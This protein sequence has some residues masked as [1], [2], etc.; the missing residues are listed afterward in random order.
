MY[1][2]TIQLN[3]WINRVCDQFEQQCQSKQAC[4]RLDAI[5]F[6]DS[7]SADVD[8]TQFNSDQREEILLEL[9]RV[10]LELASQHE[11]SLS[12]ASLRDRYPQYQHL[13]DRLGDSNPNLIGFASG[14]STLRRGLRELFQLPDNSNDQSFVVQEGAS[15]ASDARNW[16]ESKIGTRMG[17]FELVSHLGSGGMGT[18]WVAKQAHPVRREVAL[19]LI[20]PGLADSHLLSR[21]RV[22]CQALAVMN[23]PNIARMLEAHVSADGQP[24]LVMELVSGLSITQHAA[25]ANL[26]VRRRVELF[27]PICLAIQHAH[28]KR[29][30]HRD[31]KPSNI[32]VASE[33]N[34]AIPKV[35]DFGLAKATEDH[36]S[37]LSLQ[38]LGGHFLG[39]PDYM[40]PEQTQVGKVDIDTRTDIYSLGAVLYELLTGCRP[41]GDRRLGELPLDDTLRIIRNQDPA[42]PSQRVRANREGS[43]DAVHELARLT[44]PR[45]LA[46]DLDWI[47][48]KAL[49]KDRNRRYESAAALAGDLTRYLQAEPVHARPPSVHYRLQKY[50][51]RHQTLI[52]SLVSIFVLLLAGTTISSWFALQMFQ[53]RITADGQRKQAEQQR[54]LAIE[55]STEAEAARNF[56]DREAERLRQESARANFQLANAR[57]E[58]NRVAEAR[59]LLDLVPEDLR[60]FEWYYCNQAFQGSDLTLYGH[61]AGVTCVAFS[62][63]GER[64]VSGSHDGTVRIWN[65]TTGAE[66][67]KFI[68]HRQNVMSVSF[69]PDGYRIASASFDGVI[70]IWDVQQNLEV[71]ELTGHSGPV[72]G[73]DYSPNGL[74]LVT[75]GEDKTLR[76][77]DATSG[78]QLQEING[79]HQSVA[80]V[81][82][83]ADSQL[84]AGG[85]RDNSIKVYH[86]DSGVAVHELN[87]HTW[88]V[89]SIQFS[90]D[91]KRM[92]SGGWDETLRIWDLSTER[93][94]QILSGHKRYINA[95]ACSPDGECVASA[96]WDHAIRIWDSKKGTQILELR[97]HVAEV[98]SI[99]YSPDGTRIAS[100]AA[101]HTVKVWD[102]TTGRRIVEL[103]GHQDN[104]FCVSFLPDGEH[105]VSGSQDKTIKLW[106]LSQAVA[107]SEFIGHTGRITQAVVSPDGTKLASC[108][109]DQSL[110]LWDIATTN[111][112]VD[113][114]V[115]VDPVFATAFSP[116]GKQVV[117][118]NQDHTL[119]LIDATN[120]AEIR[121]FTGHTSAISTVAFAANGRRIA[122]GGLD[123]S[124]IIW[125]PAVVKP[126]RVLTGHTSWVESVQ[127]SADGTRLLSA[128][129]DNA[130]KMWDVESG[131]EILN[132]SGHNDRVFSAVFSPDGRRI[133]SGSNDNTIKLWDA[134][135]GHELLEFKGH[136]LYV[137]SVAFS[138]DGWTIAS[139]G[140]DKSIKLWTANREQEFRELRGHKFNVQSVAISENGQ[141]IFSR[142]GD[143]QFVWDLLTG[144][145]IEGGTWEINANNQFSPDGRWWVSKRNQS[146]WLVDLHFKKICDEKNY[147]V[148]KARPKV[149]WH[150]EQLARA[151]QD[152]DKYASAF[153]LR[154]LEGID[155]DAVD[156]Q[157]FLLE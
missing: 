59:L 139:C 50:V 155:R 95:V 145:R 147:R 77:W 28:Q 131:T 88:P 22:E 108:A 100:C 120:G 34:K 37:D 140:T 26:D 86:A 60:H 90:G 148:A 46:G 80:C 112:D 10:Q 7:V 76:V 39:T 54:E 11:S 52:A 29:I 45:E 33:G 89:L 94:L 84:V 71:I 40:S 17:P 115:G 64:L 101:D 98:L 125:D 109:D 113:V 75:G 136:I 48:M 74:L 63:D 126:L 121:I 153:H 117:V 85:S 61:E 106:N 151:Q 73:I 82:F 142:A 149:W 13:V 2:A 18:V 49:E 96:G 103:L 99:C 107:T 41:L 47:V 134:T 81:A 123:S 130:I 58:Q 25:Q 129:T 44:Q 12:P 105:L 65:S 43:A 68:G 9:W 51:R 16:A 15:D 67:A 118:A 127:F 133:A 146:V 83:S 128:S 154:R 38:S 62:A 31:L 137:W 36:A 56:A 35:I 30:I 66:L 87:G 114:P 6:L 78:Q 102:V 69:A 111:L 138:P 124:I 21:F 79:F 116:D 72:Y 42:L 92:I 150:R 144:E 27:L 70:T 91:G 135:D 14:Q 119:K 5:A 110:K 19:K 1:A 132:F 141:Y 23:H 24:F 55:M 4:E 97:G 8:S 3:L 93:E 152:G 57:W 104:V 143:E 53:A 157:S 20:R 122:S 156:Q 32:L